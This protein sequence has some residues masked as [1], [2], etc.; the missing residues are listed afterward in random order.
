M[1]INFITF[2][3]LK[4]IDIMYD[5]HIHTNQTDGQE[6]IETM[7]KTAIDKGLNK[8]AFTEHVRKNSDWF[9]KFAESVK[10]TASKYS[11]IEVL[12]GAETKVLDKY[13]NLDISDTILEKSDIILGS[14]HSIPDEKGGFID[15]STL[16]PWELA[17]IEFELSKGMLKYAP[18]DVLAHPGGMY[19]SRYGGFPIEYFKELMILAKAN[20]KAIEFNSKYIKNAYDFLSA[21]GDIDPALS[22]G[23]DAHKAEEVG[24]C[25]HMLNQ[26]EYKTFQR[27]A[28]K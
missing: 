19:S 23:S 4:D 14:V 11:G 15:F 25:K 8:I 17:E 24:N 28:S 7:I 13:G 27:R 21:C 26:F 16:T 10:E 1:S 3:E 20:D 2:N 6:S 5:F 22:V 18:I 12:V 9:G